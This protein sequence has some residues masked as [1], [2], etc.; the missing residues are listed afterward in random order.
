[1]NPRKVFKKGGGLFLAGD[2][3][4]PKKNGAVLNISQI[5]KAVMTSEAESE[6]G[7]LFINA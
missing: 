6:M 4:N 5:I 2:N 7:E 3:I 1:M